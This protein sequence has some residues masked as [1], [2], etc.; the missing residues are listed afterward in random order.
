L[1][2]AEHV[3]RYLGR[4]VGVEPVVDSRQSD[5]GGVGDVS[6]A[7]ELEQ[8]GGCRAIRSPVAAVDRAGVVVALALSNSQQ[9]LGA[10]AVDASPFDDDDR[11]YVGGSGGW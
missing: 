3:C 10:D 5:T 1:I 6:A 2:D 7:D 4:T 9:S 11:L 8:A